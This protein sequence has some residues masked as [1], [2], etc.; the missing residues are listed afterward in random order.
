MPL[1]YRDRCFC[2]EIFN[3]LEKTYGV[4]PSHQYINGNHGHIKRAN[5]I[6]MKYRINYIKGGLKGSLRSEV[7]DHTGFAALSFS[8]IE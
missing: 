2:G 4:C 6:K 3:L 1:L 8:G 7:K 5:P